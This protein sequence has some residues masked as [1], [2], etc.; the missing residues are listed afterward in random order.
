MKFSGH[1]FRTGA[2]PTPFEATYTFNP[3]RS[4]DHSGSTILCPL[5]VWKVC[6]WVVEIYKSKPMRPHTALTVASLAIRIQIPNFP[7]D[8]HLRGHGLASRRAS[9]APPPPE[10]SPDKGYQCILR[11]RCQIEAQADLHEHPVADV[12]KLREGEPPPDLAPE[13]GF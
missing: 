12:S 1:N 4:A 6:L 8:A 13:T 7:S 11:G 2:N 10:A 3:I 9:A 5:I